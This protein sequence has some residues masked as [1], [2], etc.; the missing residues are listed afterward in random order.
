MYAS[1]NYID[2]FFAGNGKAV[3]GRQIENL[4]QIPLEDRNR[5]AKNL[6]RIRRSRRELIDSNKTILPDG[7]I[8][9][10]RWRLIP[11]LGSDGKL[12]EIKAIGELME[13]NSANIPCG[14]KCGVI[15]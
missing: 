4:Q 9:N 14:G 5:I 15:P 1:R 2:I 13:N 3:I 8:V 10:T 7:S 12:V 6:R 11:I